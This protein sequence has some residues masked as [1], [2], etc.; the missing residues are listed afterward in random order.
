VDFETRLT[1]PPQ[2]ATRVRLSFVS[3]R[4][5]TTVA[6]MAIADEGK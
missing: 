3:S 6:P 1:Q 2:G 5:Q 4:Q